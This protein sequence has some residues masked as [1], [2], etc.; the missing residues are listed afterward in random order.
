MTTLKATDELVTV[1]ERAWL[2]A[3]EGH[4]V[5]IRR[6]LDAV[7]PL[8]EKQLRT[9]IAMEIRDV[10]ICGD[11]AGDHINFIEKPCYYGE[12]AAQIAEGVA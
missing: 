8:V 3:D 2:S 1:Y 5:D 12:L 6:G 4:D 9:Q 11:C 10:L 7:L